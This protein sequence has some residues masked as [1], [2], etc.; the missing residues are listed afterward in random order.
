MVTIFH[1][2]RLPSRSKRRG[3]STELCASMKPGVLFLG[4]FLATFFAIS[5]PQSFALALTITRRA[6]LFGAAA[7][8]LPG[9]ELANAAT[10]LPEEYRQVSMKSGRCMAFLVEVVTVSVSEGVRESRVYQPSF[11]YL[12]SNFRHILTGHAWCWKCR[13]E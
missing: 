13:H 9:C 12:W 7:S 8:A 11:V 4:T 10:T 5:I 2:S 3:N 6:A 1:L